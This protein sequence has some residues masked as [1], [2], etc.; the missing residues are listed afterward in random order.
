MPSIAD[1]YGIV[2][3]NRRLHKCALFIR[4]FA[5]SKKKRK[6]ITDRTISK[7]QQDRAEE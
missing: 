6:Q 7:A 5:L 2:V 3:V 1:D 4:Q